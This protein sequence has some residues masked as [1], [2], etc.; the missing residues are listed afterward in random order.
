M[1]RIS[2]RNTIFVFFCICV[3]AA[4]S[5]AQQ[6]VGGIRANVRDASPMLGSGGYNAPV[7]RFRYNAGNLFI[8]G[9]VTGGKSFRGFVP[10]SSATQF[11]GTLG[12]SSL[13][14]FERE[15]INLHQIRSGYLYGRARPYFNPGS[16]ILPLSARRYA[17]PGSSMPK[18]STPSLNAAAIGSGGLGLPHNYNIDVNKVHL[19]AGIRPSDV[20]VPSAAINVYQQPIQ[21]AE[22]VG[23]GQARKYEREAKFIER[24]KDSEQGINEPSVPGLLAEPSPSQGQETQQVNQQGPKKSFSQMLMEQA[25]QAE[26]IETSLVPKKE[27]AESAKRLILESKKRTIRNKGNRLA[28]QP[29]NEKANFVVTSLAGESKDLF[30]QTMRSAQGLMIQGRFL[31]AY[32]EYL[33]AQ[34]IQPKDPLPLFGQ[35]H[36]LIAAGKFKSAAK[37]LEEALERFDGFIRLRLKGERLI[38]SKS[39]LHRRANQLADLLLRYPNN[40]QIKFLLGYLKILSGDREAGLALMRASRS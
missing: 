16:T 6:R 35:V 1:V 18:T 38:G 4:T 14:S 21:S 20:L 30:T 36:A 13:S 27:F 29:I 39:V 22:T 26:P 24:Q 31:L 33:R 40:K 34:A 15:S 17:I 37:T 5:S 3:F 9:N 19:P 32:D 10:Y 7:R 2:I 25:S 11:Q 23:K 12:S 28:T 8:T